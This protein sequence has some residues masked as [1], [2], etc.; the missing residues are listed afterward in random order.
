MNRT[1][2]ITLF[3]EYFSHEHLGKD[4]FFVPYVLGKK[5]GYNV[6]IVYPQTTDN[7]DLPNIVKGVNLI[8]LVIDL[9]APNREKVVAN[10]MFRYIWNNARDIDIMIRFFD[11]DISRKAAFLYKLRNPNGV[12]Y[13]KM[14]VNP[15]TIPDYNT[16]SYLRRTLRF[17][18]NNFY[19]RFVDIVSC[20]TQFALKKL[21]ETPN[22]YYQW[23]DK[24]IY[25]PNGFDEELLSTYN[26]KERDFKQKENIIL[27]VARLGSPEKNT[28]MLLE[29][30]SM[31]DLKDWKFYLIG[32]VEPKFIEEVNRFYHKNKDKVEN[33]IFVGPVY[34]KKVLWDFYNRSKVFVLTSRFESF[35]LVYTEAQ[36]FQNYIISTR[37]GAAMDVILENRYGE[38]IDQDDHIGL[39]QKISRI[40][41]NEKN[42][43]V[44]SDFEVN[45][46]SWETRLDIVVERIRQ[47]QL[48]DNNR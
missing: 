43:D 23:D 7:K 15:Y 24:L 33:V 42:I 40:I 4:P 14:D 19:K 46:L 28:Q 12:F 30:L 36:R 2:N 6:N 21:R 25:M 47:I 5:M 41:N 26:F 17:L 1:K 34:D 13:I 8:P 20:E 29:A 39:S 11:Y 10:A 44:Y 37:V 32:P 3:F 22:S 27:T 48:K 9:K 31:T 45:M 38:F 35:G 16:G 18:K